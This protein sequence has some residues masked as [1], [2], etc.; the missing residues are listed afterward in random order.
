MK[1]VIKHSKKGI[2]MV[3][4]L[5]TLLSFANETALF[6]IKNDAK[7][8]ILTLYNVKQGNLLS[9]KDINGVILFKEYIEKSGTYNKGFDLTTLP[10]G[11]YIF[12]LDKDMEINS[13]PFTVSSNIVDFD[14]ENEKTIFKPFTRV[15]GDFVYISKLALNK[16]PLKIEVYFTSFDSNDSELV[17]SENIGN[18]KTIK[19]IY[20]LDGLKFGT[21][22]IVFFTEG[23]QFT[24]IIN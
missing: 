10:D 18:T 9:V 3:T 17:L 6:N 8:T 15:K 22:K 23:K 1:N 16:E 5:A 14:K 11:N 20:K 13:I 2:L 4:M 7:K 21:Y 24:K 19:R 12:E